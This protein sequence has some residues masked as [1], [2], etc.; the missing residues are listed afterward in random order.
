M[1][2][3][4]YS[5]TGATSFD[6]GSIDG[7]SLSVGDSAR[8]VFALAGNTGI[9]ASQ[10]ALISINSEIQ[11]DSNSAFGGGYNATALVSGGFARRNHR[12]GGSISLGG[13]AK[14][15]RVGAAA[16]VLCGLMAAPCFAAPL[17]GR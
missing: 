2:D 1:D 8:G 9:G 6:N 7:G 16:L 15:L 3:E 17:A 5:T 12:N 14:M 11:A 4:A 13:S 10:N